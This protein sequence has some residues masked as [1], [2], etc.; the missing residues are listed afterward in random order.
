MYIKNHLDETNRYCAG[1]ETEH[2][3]LRTGVG[4]CVAAAFLLAL[5]IFGM[6]RGRALVAFLAASCLFAIV[7]LL[8]KTVKLTKSQ[9][10][11]VV[12]LGIIAILFRLYFLDY[13]SLDYQDFLA[14]WAA[15]FRNNGGVAALG[16]Q[17]G[18][19]NFPYLYFLALFSYI[20][21]NDLYL[22]K[23]LSTAFDII[24]ALYGM[25]LVL[26]LSENRN[27]GL[28][29][30]FTL[31]M[32]PTVVANSSMWA[33]CDSIYTGFLLMMLYYAMQE[34]PSATMV[35]AALAFAF[36]L[37]AIFLLPVLLVF[38]MMGR[39][40]LK[41]FLLLPGVYLL[42]C[43]PAFLWGRPVADALLIYLEQA[44]STKHSL[45]YNAPSVFGLFRA[46]AEAISLLSLLGILCSAALIFACC[47]VVFL[48]AKRMNNRD[49]LFVSLFLCIG[50]P[51]F[52]PSMHDRYFFLADCLSVVA[53]FAVGASIPYP[54]AVQVASL[55]CY[56][57]YFKRVYTLP[58]RV[59]ST[60]MGCALVY[61]AY[62][63]F[64]K[65]EKAPKRAQVQDDG[66]AS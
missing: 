40:R 50:I 7:V 15:Y 42:S 65:Q 10:G 49:L 8:A 62:E 56:D 45:N 2:W 47:G 22:I 54:V 64:F 46:P 19:Y 24:L 59:A 16:D 58:L 32:L 35:C 1:E 61:T 18:N 31:L 43:L 53:V 41:H 52:L 26:H 4:L 14:K 57:A 29:C 20:P 37:Q 28:A 36:K 17:I 66:G 12:M 33:Q 3:M 9:L 11:A 38:W 6:L 55:F 51:F 30:F 34:Q 13:Q 48:R 23:F 63:S 44:D 21:M 25:K 5:R 39:V 27:L 60:L